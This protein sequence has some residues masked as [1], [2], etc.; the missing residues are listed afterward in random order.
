MCRMFFRYHSINTFLAL[1]AMLLSSVDSIPRY[2]I[3]STNIGNATQP[4]FFYQLSDSAL[5]NFGLISAWPKPPGWL[6][7]LD[8]KTVELILS[9]AIFTFSSLPTSGFSKPYR[10]IGPDSNKRLAALNTRLIVRQYTATNLTA[11]ADIEGHY[12]YPAAPM[13]NGEVLT[14]SIIVHESLIHN[15]EEKWN[16]TAFLMCYVNKEHGVDRCTGMIMLQKDLF[17]L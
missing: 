13:K 8:P 14:A 5:D 15:K 16:E 4:F 9:T 1:A 12:G 6:R 3:K 11:S 2:D 10:S 17:T 7:P